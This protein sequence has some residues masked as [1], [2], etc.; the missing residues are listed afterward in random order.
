MFRLKKNQKFSVSACIT[1][2][3]NIKQSKG[4]LNSF[5][6]KIIS[7][8]L[9]L[10]I[11]PT[12]VQAFSLVAL[13]LINPTDGTF[14]GT[15][16]NP[17]SNETNKVRVPHSLDNA[18]RWD[19]VN[20]IDGVGTNRSL[21]NGLEYNF[22]GGSIENFFNFFTFEPFTTLTQFTKAINSGFAQWAN[23][24]SVSFTKVD[25]PVVNTEGISGNRIQGTEIDIL[26]GLP[27]GSVDFG[28]VT[29]IWGVDQKTR[30]TN[31]F[32]SDNSGLF[33]SSRIYA[34]D[35][36]MNNNITWKLSDWQATFTHELGHAL[37]LGDVELAF[38]FFDNNKTIN[39]F[40]PINQNGDVR[41]NLIDLGD[42]TIDATSG[43]LMRSRF[44]GL[45]ELQNDDI[46]GIQFLYPTNVPEPGT[47]VGLLAVV[48]GLGFTRYKYKFNE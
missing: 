3:G 37:G 41:E 32:S 25:I 34:V 5:L 4:I 7:I 48:T 26:A 44:T 31:G 38:S 35:L 14:T 27:V 46:G 16:L 30:L 23:N 10:V 15:R 47:L 22:Q 13:D 21:V 39:D 19:S 29:R 2:I 12:D 42:L 9:P 33:P 43:I 6:F 1:L 28:G 20:R 45:T 36:F 40:L 24:S 11:I 18:P 8:G 17:F